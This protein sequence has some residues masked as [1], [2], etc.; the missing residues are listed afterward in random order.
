M[1]R[2]G[3]GIPYRVGTKTGAPLAQDPGQ[4]IAASLTAAGY[5]AE[6]VTGFPVLDSDAAKA[7]L[8]S[9]PTDRHI[10]VTVSKWGSDPP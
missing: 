4:S 5:K 6:D 3:F 7:K 1:T 8:L 10:L 9:V 2:C